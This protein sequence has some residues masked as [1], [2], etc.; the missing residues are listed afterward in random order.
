[1]FA[2]CDNEDSGFIEPNE[3]NKG[4]INVQSQV[5]ANEFALWKSVRCFNQSK[6]KLKL[7]LS[8]IVLSIYLVGYCRMI[9]KLIIVNCHHLKRQL[10]NFAF[11]RFWFLHSF[12]TFPY[13]FNTFFTVNPIDS[14]SSIYKKKK[15]YSIIIHWTT[16]K[17]ECSNVETNS[18]V[19]WIVLILILIFE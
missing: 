4:K 16:I 1:M 18:H 2:Q 3:M 9:Q 14:S 10:L 11:R 19:W 13:L 12:N 5:E 7:K 15:K 6:L 17:K 8:T